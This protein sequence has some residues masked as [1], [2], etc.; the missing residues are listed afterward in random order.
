MGEGRGALDEKEPLWNWKDAGF[1]IE[2]KVGGRVWGG[3]LSKGLIGKGG[4]KKKETY[5]RGAEGARDETNVVMRKREFP[6]KR[7]S[8]GHKLKRC[9]KEKREGGGLGCM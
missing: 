1:G 6:G 5:Y 8:R 9:A 3:R 2:H 7:N 4:T